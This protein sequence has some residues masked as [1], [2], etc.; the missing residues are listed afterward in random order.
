M[1]VQWIIIILSVFTGLASSC[2][3]YYYS[4]IETNQWKVNKLDNG[5]FTQENDTVA[6]TYCFY[7]ENLPIE[8][9]I[10]NKLDQP[11]FLDWQQSAIIVEDAVTSYYNKNILVKG[12]V[13]SNTYTYRDYLFPHTNYSNTFGNFAGQ[14]SV[15]EGVAFIPPKSMINSTPVTLDNFTFDRIRNDVYSKGKFEGI[16]S[17]V[18]NVK[19]LKFKEDESPLRFRSY[20][21]LYTI[22]PNGVREKQMTYEQSFYIS[23]LMKS[24][25]LRPKNVP[26]HQ[27]QRGDFFYVRKEKGNSIA[28]ITAGVVAIGVAGVAIEASSPRRN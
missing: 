15:P 6:I 12:E 8:I 17:N 24:G 2:T 19:I 5:D 21:T 28:F 9:T 26:A 23:T 25:S 4:T 27:Q 10:Y 14:A 18:K 11:L 16:D 3:T 22:T 7:G 13:N 20:L 1:K